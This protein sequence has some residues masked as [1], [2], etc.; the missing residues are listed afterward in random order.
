MK[1]IRRWKW[2]YLLLTLAVMALGI[3]LMIWPGISAEIL[4]YILGAILTVVG[5]VR[6]VCYFRR[7]ISV[8]W[9]RYEL[10][11]G[12]LDA[13]LG[14]YFFSHPVNV[15]LILPIV[16]GIMIIVDSVFHLQTALELRGIGVRRWW[17]LLLFAVV[18]ILVALGLIRNPFE[19]SMTLMVYL[20]ISLVIDSVQSIYYIHQVAKDVRRL[21]PI[22]AEFVEVE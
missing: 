17:L 1:E 16:V 3:C 19:G 7:G 11:L 18:S 10:P 13:L 14:I 8:L 2:S 22:E 20:G 5:V 12:I 4:C 21:A 15:L 6:I 9:H